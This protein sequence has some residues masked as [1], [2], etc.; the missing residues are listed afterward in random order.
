M[1]KLAALTPAVG[2]KADHTATGKFTRIKFRK[3]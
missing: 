1:I 2:I 3:N